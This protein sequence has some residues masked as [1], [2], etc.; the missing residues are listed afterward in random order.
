MNNERVFNL[1]TKTPKYTSDL[2][3]EKKKSSKTAHENEVTQ[4]RAGIESE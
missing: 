3:N 4:F 1:I 2:Q